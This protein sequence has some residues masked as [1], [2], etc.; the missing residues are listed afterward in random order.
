MAGAP[1]AIKSVVEPK[2]FG[3]I[4]VAMCVAPAAAL[5][6]LLAK[7]EAAGGAVDL[8]PV[9]DALVNVGGVTLD[10]SALSQP[11]EQMV[12]QLK[13]AAATLSAVPWPED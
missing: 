1:T 8:A 13:Q 10:T 3:V 7:L 6:E 9:T 4:S 2:L 12:A 5:N 11:V